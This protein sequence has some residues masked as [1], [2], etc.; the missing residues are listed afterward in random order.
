[1][2]KDIGGVHLLRRDRRLGLGDAYRTGFT[3]GLA[4]GFDAMVEMDSDLSHD[5]ADLVRLLAGLVDQDVVIGSRYVSGGSIPRWGVHRRLLSRA[6]NAYSSLM[7]GL[8]VRDMT[9]GFRVYR[10]EVLRSIDL[11]HVRANGYGFQIE[12][13]YRAAQAG[14]RIAEV[15]IQFVD[16]EAGESKMSASTIVEALLLVT[17]WGVMRGAPRLGVAL[18]SG[19]RRCP[20][21]TPTWGE[22]R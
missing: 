13:T 17:H 19:G 4:R 16:R 18:A 7:L 6:G 15:P 2:G 10:A 22:S 14:A 21:M 8:P 1:M 12:M 9:S 3:W 5:P 20:T 11:N